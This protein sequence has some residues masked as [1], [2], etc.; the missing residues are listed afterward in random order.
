M[1][2]PRVNAKSGKV[3]SRFRSLPSTPRER[4]PMPSQRCRRP[5]AVCLP[6]GSPFAVWWRRRSPR[7]GVAKRRSATA[8]RYSGV[9]DL[10]SVPELHGPIDARLF[11]ERFVA[12]RT[13]VIV[14]GGVQ[15]ETMAVLADDAALDAAAGDCQLQVEVP[16]LPPTPSLRLGQ[17][18]HSS[19]LTAHH[20]LACVALIPI[21]HCAAPTHGC[22]S[23]CVRAPTPSAR[24]TGGAC[25]SA[26]CCT[27]WAGP[28]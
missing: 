25:V 9:R 17:P 10:R 24:A 13:P 28:C 12:T 1:V 6:H 2:C 4:V 5:S 18:T 16:T 27:R 8:D 19:L 21:T 22:R 3:F 20:S 23:R 15:R 11:F 7:S 14:R 26:R